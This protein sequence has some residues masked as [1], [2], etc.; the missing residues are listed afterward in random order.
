MNNKYF[1]AKR[2]HQENEKKGLNGYSTHKFQCPYCPEKFGRALE[3]L[4]NAHVNAHT[5]KALEC[6]SSGEFL[7]YITQWFPI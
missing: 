7:N 2:H 1:H 5:G 3:G 4:F 6:V